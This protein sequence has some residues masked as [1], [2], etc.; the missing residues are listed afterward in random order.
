MDE[1]KEL[2]MAIKH[3][4]EVT[5]AKVT[6]MQDELVHLRKD[7]NAIKSDVEVLKTDVS[8]LKTDVSI[9]KT[10]VSILKTDVAELKNGQERQDRILESLALHAL[11]QESMIRE[12]QRMK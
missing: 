1:T 5:G 11:E 3:S 10:D 12:L 6:A 2:L 9:L 4:V 7:V 8:I